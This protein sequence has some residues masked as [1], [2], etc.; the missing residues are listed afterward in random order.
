MAHHDKSGSKGRRSKQSAP[1]SKSQQRG[2]VQLTVEDRKLLQ[3]TLVLAQTYAKEPILVMSLVER[4]YDQLI[5]TRG[6]EACLAIVSE[7]LRQMDRERCFT[8]L[9]SIFLA[10]AKQRKFKE[11]R[12]VMAWMKLGPLGRLS[13][14]GSMA[15]VSCAEDQPELVQKM[16]ELIPFIEGKSECFEALSK[17]FQVT[18]DLAD[19]E[20]VQGLARER[21]G[22]PTS[23]CTRDLRVVIE[24]AAFTDG[25][26]LMRVAIRALEGVRAPEVIRACVAKVLQTISVWDRARLIEL[27][28]QLPGSPL[29]PEIRRMAVEARDR[30]EMQ[31]LEEAEFGS[32]E[33]LTA[34]S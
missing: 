25:T 9:P 26:Q 27:A 20:A 8:L 21:F 16:R 33:I 2:G 30:D 12:Q 22:D 34:T 1:V 24:L 7:V 17:I 10:F 13:L 6:V 11:A 18:R 23:V 19:F 28:D 3:Q 14:Y 5:Q 4:M 15:Q 31:R 32:G 29:E